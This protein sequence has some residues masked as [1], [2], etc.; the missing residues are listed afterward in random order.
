MLEIGSGGSAKV[1]IEYDSDKT[2][3]GISDVKSQL[4]AFMDSTNKITG[5]F[6]R[7]FAELSGESINNYREQVNEYMVSA[8]L[9]EDYITI[10]VDLVN[11]MD[12]EISEAERKSANM[13]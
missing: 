9:A 10:L 7:I 12:D 3:Q 4:S 13:F 1:T 11:L 2:L 6:D 5:E 8:K